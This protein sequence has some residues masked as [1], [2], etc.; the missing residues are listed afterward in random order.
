VLGIQAQ[1]LVIVAKRLLEVAHLANQPTPLSENSQ[2]TGNL[3]T[4]GR[5]P[6]TK[7]RRDPSPVG[8]PDHEPRV[9]RNALPK[10]HTAW[11]DAS[12]FDDLRHLLPSACLSACH[13]ARCVGARAC[14]P[15]RCRSRSSASAPPPSSGSCPLL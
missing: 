9:E 7:F 10:A 11:V 13:A 12:A 2:G 14:A 3:R 5:G 1:R 6:T 15:T 4:G 8:V